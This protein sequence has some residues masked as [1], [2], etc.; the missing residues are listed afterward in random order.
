MK[1]VSTIEDLVQAVDE[2]HK[3]GVIGVQII[4]QKGAAL[5]PRDDFIPSAKAENFRLNSE[6]KLD[7]LEGD[8]I[9]L[10]GKFS[11][12]LDLGQ[13]ARTD[14][15]IV[16]PLELCNKTTE[17]HNDLA[18]FVPEKGQR[19][20]DP[21]IIHISLEW[22][23][24][25]NVTKKEYSLAQFDVLENTLDVIEKGRSEELTEL[26]SRKFELRLKV[27]RNLKVQLKKTGEEYKTS[28]EGD[29]FN[30]LTAYAPYAV[31]Y[32]HPYVVKGQ[33]KS[34]TPVEVRFYADRAEVLEA[35]SFNTETVSR[36]INSGL[37]YDEAAATGKGIDEIPESRGTTVTNM[38]VSDIIFGK[39]RA[40]SHEEAELFAKK[41][42]GLP[43]VDILPAYKRAWKLSS[44]D[45]I[46]AFNKRAEILAWKALE[47]L[48]VEVVKA[49]EDHG[50]AVTLSTCFSR[51]VR[52]SEEDILTSM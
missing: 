48:K 20:D 30:D 5:L 8:P 10:G 45:R 7:V 49:F 24:R 18:V 11:L 25:F 1:K 13:V 50:T 36:Y 40:V 46:K 15:A 4:P 27:S 38:V 39:P 29:Y 35:V 42:L 3:L 26:L 52:I 6:R 2:L 12:Y 14:R 22:G 31:D 16:V 41:E 37:S 19:T 9:T 23:R 32:D 17:L 43:Y 28:L 21:A 44:Q 34:K 51:E 33:N 47:N